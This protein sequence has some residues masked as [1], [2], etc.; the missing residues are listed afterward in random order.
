MPAFSAII[1]KFDKKGEKS[2]WTYITVDHEQILKI[3]P[4]CKKTFRVKGTIDKIN[5]KQQALLPMGN[6]E[7]ILTLKAELRKKL[8]KKLGELVH[9]RLEKDEEE[10]TLNKDFIDCLMDDKNALSFFKTLSPSHQ[11]YFSNWIESAKTIETKAKRIA[12]AIEGLKQKLGYSEM[13]RHYKAL[14]N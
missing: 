14:K 1:E 3:N 13:I 6:G 12:Q 5:I 4:G 2:G 9:L 7:F 10:I 11:R 8:G